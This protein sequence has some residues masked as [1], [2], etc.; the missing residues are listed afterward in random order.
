MDQVDERDRSAAI[1]RLNDLFTCG[2][3]SLE[4]HSG[5]SD[6]V[7][8]ATTL[9]QLEAAMFSLPPVVRLT[10]ASRRLAGKLVLNVPDGNLQLG[11]GWQ[12]ASNT[13]IRT[14]VGSARLDLTSA[15]WDAPEI[16][17]RLE[18]WGSIEV[19][20]PQGVAVQVTG[21]MG[22]IQLE[23][24]AAPVPGGP[25]L[26][27]SSSGPAGVIRIRHPSAY[28]AGFMKRRRQQV[29][30]VLNA[31]TRQEAPG[32]LDDRGASRYSFNTAKVPRESTQ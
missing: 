12:L 23:A 9:A 20:V 4:L 30:R 7:I 6:E 24:L 29:R 28:V 8:A 16:D 31:M 3:L 32:S 22:R 19:V 17:L 10:P 5:R 11:S 13:T 14:G 27:I 2:N 18:T 1:R 21:G 25:L 15:S 26:R